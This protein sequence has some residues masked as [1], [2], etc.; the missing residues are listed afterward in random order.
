MR[1]AI[2]VKMILAARDMSIGDLAEKLGT[3]QQNIT[4]KLN[5]D[6]FSENDLHQIAK[7]CNASY[8]GFFT[9][10]DSNKQI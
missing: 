4:A 3:T 9:L 1:M 2:K 5:R 8:E 6:N 10:N 7:A